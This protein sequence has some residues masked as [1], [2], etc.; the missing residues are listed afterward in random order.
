[1]TS[2]THI[3]DRLSEAKKIE[4]ENQRENAS[5]ILNAPSGGSQEELDAYREAIRLWPLSDNECSEK[6]STRIH[7]AVTSPIMDENVI[8]DVLLK[9]WRTLFHCG[10]RV[11]NRR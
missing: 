3:A 1:M 5:N 6:T 9:L 7:I 4:W 8:R 11:E 10:E 2:V